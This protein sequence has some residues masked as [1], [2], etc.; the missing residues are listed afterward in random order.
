MYTEGFVY[1]G[2]LILYMDCIC[3]SQLCRNAFKKIIRIN[4]TFVRLLPKTLINTIWNGLCVSEPSG[5]KQG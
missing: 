3:V 4:K 2:G 5:L 1:R